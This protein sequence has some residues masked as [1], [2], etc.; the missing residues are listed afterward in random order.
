MPKF[1][2]DAQGFTV[3]PDGP[4]RK[5]VDRCYLFHGSTIVFDAGTAE[6]VCG[7]AADRKIGIRMNEAGEFVLGDFQPTRTITKGRYKRLAVTG[8]KDAILK[9]YGDTERVFLDTVVVT[10]DGGKPEAVIL[11]PVD[12]EA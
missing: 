4:S 7:I 11:K 10:D 5:P 8:F 6:I 9:V 1:D 12:L 2:P 3:V